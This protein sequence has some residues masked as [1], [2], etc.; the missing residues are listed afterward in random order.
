MAADWSMMPATLERAVAGNESPCTAESC[1]RGLAES[2][3]AN[4]GRVARDAA[5]VS[6]EHVR[7]AVIDCREDVARHRTLVNEARRRVE[8]E[9]AVVVGIVTLVDVGRSV[10]VARHVLI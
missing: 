3:E 8:G 7:E 6:L 9:R 2:S 10:A 4:G 1:R 5:S